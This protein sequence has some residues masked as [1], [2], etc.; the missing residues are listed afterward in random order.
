M[1]RITK[2]VL[3]GAGLR[4]TLL[5]GKRLNY[6]EVSLLSG[7]KLLERKRLTRA[8]ANRRLAEKFAKRKSCGAPGIPSDR[9]LGHPTR[10]IP[11]LRFESYTR[12]LRAAIN[13]TITLIRSRWNKISRHR[14]A[15]VSQLAIRFPAHARRDSHVFSSGDEGKAR[16]ATAADE[17]GN[18][19]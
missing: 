3:A 16:A 8:D 1:S 15:P 13:I 5:P 19:K 6:P 14:G 4:V 11:S 2:K 10:L 12:V 7:K 18:S 17:N 9:I